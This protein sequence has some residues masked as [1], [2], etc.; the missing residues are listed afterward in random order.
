M[1]PNCARAA[2]VDKFKKYR[3]IEIVYFERQNYTKCGH[4]DGWSK[5]G[6][7][8]NTVTVQLASLISIQ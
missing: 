3:V 6:R 1:T 2:C 8:L 7:A 5:W 4:S